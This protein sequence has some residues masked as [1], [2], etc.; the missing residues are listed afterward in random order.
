MTDI[1]K[2]KEYTFDTVN[3]LSKE[4]IDGNYRNKSYTFSI[5]EVKNGELK[6]RIEADGYYNWSAVYG[7]FDGEGK[8]QYVGKAYTHVGRR[9][10]DHIEQNS[11]GDDWSV[12]VI[13]S[14]LWICTHEWVEAQLHG[15]WK[16]TEHWQ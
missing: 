8:V 9:L 7:F 5:P 6:R 2:M 1:E 10:L 14:K 4:M 11:V 15:K 13:Y 16:H 3:K 12:L